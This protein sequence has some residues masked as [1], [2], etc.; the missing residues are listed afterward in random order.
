MG[1]LE[2]KAEEKLEIDFTRWWSN[3]REKIFPLV[4]Y[5]GASIS[6]VMEK[7]PECATA[8]TECIEKAKLDAFKHGV[9]LT[10]LGGIVGDQRFMLM[11][12]A[13]EQLDLPGMPAMG[14]R[15]GG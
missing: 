7:P 2:A 13:I 3:A 8:V 11:F 10:I 6:F 12:T 1:L 9:A 14:K 5:S 4:V 15:A